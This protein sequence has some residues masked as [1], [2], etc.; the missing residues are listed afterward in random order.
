M[1]LSLFSRVHTA[2]HVGKVVYTGK[3]LLFLFILKK[4]TV[5]RFCCARTWGSVFYI[6]IKGV[7]FEGKYGDRNEVVTR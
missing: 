5:T 3:S 4:T 6:R 7:G 1:K 2:R